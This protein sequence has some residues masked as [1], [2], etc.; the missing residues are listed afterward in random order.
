M[1]F[2]CDLYLAVLSDYICIV[3]QQ[4][5]AVTINTCHNDKG[6]YAAST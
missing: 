1:A 5:Q 4:K 3:D 6:I 2:I